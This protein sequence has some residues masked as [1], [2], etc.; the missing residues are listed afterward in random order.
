MMTH[1]KVNLKEW[2]IASLVVKENQENQENLENLE[3]LEK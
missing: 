1:Q 2:P 3:N